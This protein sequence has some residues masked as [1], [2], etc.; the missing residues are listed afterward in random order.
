MIC[1]RRRGKFY[2]FDYMLGAHRHAA[3]GSLGTKNKQSAVHLLRRLDNALFEGPDSAQWEYLHRVLPPNT[4]KQLAALVGISEVFLLTWTDLRSMYVADLEKRAQLKKMAENSKKTYLRSLNNFETFLAS[5]GTPNPILRTIDRELATEFKYSRIESIRKR[6]GDN[7]GSGYTV[8]LAVMHACFKFALERKKVKENPFMCEANTGSEQ[9]GAQPY[10]G[11]ELLR[12]REHASDVWLMFMLFRWTGLRES[13]VA[14]LTWEEVDFQK[15]EIRK[16]T[17]KSGGT[18]QAIVPLH[19]ELLQAL[20]SEREARN[21]EPHDRVL[22][23]ASGEPYTESDLYAAIVKLGEQAGVKVKPHRFRDT[24]AVD[25]LF[26]DIDP[27]QVARILAITEATIKRC[28]L[29]NVLPLR[30]QTQKKLNSGRKLEDL[31]SVA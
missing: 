30:E 5:R 21:P 13:D 17:K 19:Q 25:A 28:Y 26:H 27:L 7:G 10:D 22:L 31:A 4:Y 2:H 11:D 18:K 24:F 15:Q 16:F 23:S 9:R 14:S 3:R 8:D 12:L 6:K 20:Q 29:P 1:L